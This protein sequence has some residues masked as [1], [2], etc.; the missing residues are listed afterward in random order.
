MRSH[1]GKST[2]DG[3]KRERGLAVIIAY[4]LGKGGLWL[5]IVLV[6]L[7]SMHMGLS[8]RLLGFAAH[9]RLHARVWSLR[10]AEL[11]VSAA[12][13]RG[14]WTIIVALFAD[15]TFSLIEGWALWTGKTW[16]KWLVVVS[17]SALL[18]LE[19]AAFVKHPHAV[20]AALFVLNVLIV[21]YLTN[22]ALREG[23]AL[24]EG[25]AT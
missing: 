5:L 7:V 4:K 21:G 25:K 2:I 24:R 6:L 11:L 13:R 16:G 8:D 9:L 1:R 10:L 22:K 19:V 23:L 14:L 18:P 3:V 15:G 17:T 20:R 12:T